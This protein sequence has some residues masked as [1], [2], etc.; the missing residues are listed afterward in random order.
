MTAARN[1]VVVGGGSA[2]CVVAAR[3]SE[4]PAATVT[5][6]EEGPS[7]WNPYI[8]YPG[9]YYKTAQGSLL[10]RYR[11]EPTPGAARDGGDTMVQASV[12]GGGS[13]VNAMV[14]IRGNPR[15][16][17]RWAQAG[18]E[19]W[20]YRDVL[21]YF[22]RSE[23]NEDF[24][25]D[26]HAVGGPLGIARPGY[27][28]PLTKTWLRACQQ[29]GFD[30]VADFNAGHQA[31]GCGIYQLTARHGRRSSAVSAFL[32][33]AMRRPNLQVLT[34]ARATRIV[35]ENGRATGVAYVRRG[36]AHTLH[37]DTEVIVSAGA[38]NSPKLLLLS[39]I[40][41]AAQLGALGIPVQADLPGVGQNLQ[42]HIEMS[43][44]Y[45]LRG[46]DSYDKYKSLRWK[47]W[48]ALQFLC[49]TGPI[50]SNLIEGGGFSRGTASDPL[51][52][53]QYFF[54]VGAGIEEGVATVPGGQGCTV[55][56]GQ[57]RPTS[58]GTV[59]LRSAEPTAP[60]T[61]APNYL[62]E[63]YDVACLTEGFLKVQEIM[64]APEMA[65]YIARP[66]FP[67]QELHDRG[68]IVAF[69]R[70]HVHAALHPTGTC[71]IGHDRLSVV[72]PELRLHGI[73]GLRVADASVMPNIVS[74]NTNAACIMIGEKAADH[75]RGFA[76]KLPRV[77]TAEAADP[78]FS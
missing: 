17:D 62:A 3:L 22:R 45:Q 56:F 60:P 47:P 51:A 52:D 64:R 43:M 70:R 71:R 20:A 69:L 7:D 25:N 58:R 19:G 5:L 18:A 4:D 13:S 63:D 24:C 23:D 37:A 26:A 72:D 73:A 67:K 49:G 42:D 1:Y 38:V 2:G 32:R 10:K 30:Y 74:G 48:A 75:I 34:G 61:I 12:L 9:T 65:R 57:V 15:D 59:A 14:Y 11:W 66:H 46:V 40:G 27:I 6:L 41:P 76:P 21:S 77:A 54:V 31:E 50:A 68:E 78:A 55:N 33:P 36:R 8:R 35:V 29:A 53:L 39:G 44:I 16:Y 28:H